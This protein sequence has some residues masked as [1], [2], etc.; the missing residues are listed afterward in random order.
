M[1]A[2]SDPVGSQEKCYAARLGDAF[3][4][5]PGGSLEQREETVHKGD[6]LTQERLTGRRHRAIS[7]S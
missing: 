5:T 4:A 1:R 7:G 3:R 6:A 2:L